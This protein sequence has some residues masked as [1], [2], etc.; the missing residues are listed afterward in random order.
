MSILNKMCNLFEVA[1]SGEKSD[2]AEINRLSEF[3]EIEVP[4]EFIDIIKEKSEIEI[5]VNKQK[6]IRIWGADGCIE[7]NTAYNIQKYIPNSLAIADDGCCNVVVYA[8]G[9]NG[10]GL[11]IVPLGDLDSDEMTFISPSL[12]SFLTQGTGTEIFNSVW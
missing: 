9:G 12:E 11:Y 8:H 2:D 4:S 3:S 7:M 5:L 6:C 10:F 1:A